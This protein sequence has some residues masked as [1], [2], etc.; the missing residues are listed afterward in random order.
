MCQSIR[1]QGGHI[2]FQVDLRSNNT[3]SGAHKEH[4]WQVWSS[5]A[6]PSAVLEKKFKM[7]QADGWTLCHGISLLELC[8]GE[9]KIYICVRMHLNL[10]MIDKYMVIIIRGL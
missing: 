2:G 3:W 10:I 6:I 4:L 5:Y 7:C 1:G 8:S 9:L